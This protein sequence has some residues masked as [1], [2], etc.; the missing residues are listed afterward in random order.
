[1]VAT[2]QQTGFL[3]NNGK[4]LTVS[5]VAQQLG[6]H[7]NSVRRWADIGILP[8]YRFGVR[9]DRRFKPEDVKIFLG[10]SSA[11]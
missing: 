2:Q 5:E 11:I 3:R 9:G 10:S 8:C 4:M 6:A 7:I 1:M